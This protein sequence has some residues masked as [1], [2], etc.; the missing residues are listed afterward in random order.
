MS[1]F[2]SVFL[3]LTLPCVF[4]N[5]HLKSDQLS[6]L[7][8]L[9]LTSCLFILNMSLSGETTTNSTIAM[10]D[11]KEI[12]R[13]VTDDL[14][15]LIGSATSYFKL[16]SERVSNIVTGSLDRACSDDVLHS[17]LTSQKESA[18]V[19]LSQFKEK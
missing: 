10:H 18:R 3:P 1:V 14:H 11:L 4:S 12:Y 8:V 5:R 2:L 15:I 16:A 9:N 6:F 7:R 19:T 17:P 13:N